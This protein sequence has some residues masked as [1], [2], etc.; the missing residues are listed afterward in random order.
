MAVDRERMADVHMGG[1]WYPGTGGF[2][3]LGIAGHSPDIGLPYD[4][5]AAQSLL[6]AAGYPGGHGLPDLVSIG[7]GTGEFSWA[8]DYLKQQWRENLG[9][10]TEWEVV[11][12][13]ANDEEGWRWPHIYQGGWVAGIPDP[14]Y[15]LRIAPHRFE[16]QIGDHRYGELVEEARRVMDQKQ[17]LAIY[18]KADRMLVDDAV[19]VPLYYNRRHELLKPWVKGYVVSPMIMSP[20]KDVVIEPH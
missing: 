20:W 18:Q 19:L 15:F 1:Y 11:E 10:E 3:A 17:R 2:I 9:V 4:P 13:T 12:W 16:V 14:D 6:S 7:S 5:I 8:R